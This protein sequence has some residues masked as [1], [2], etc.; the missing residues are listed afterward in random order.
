MGQAGRHTGGVRR[1]GTGPLRGPGGQAPAPPP[2]LDATTTPV[3]SS[4]GQGAGRLG[5]TSFTAQT[6]HSRRGGGV[7]V[8]DAEGHA[9]AEIRGPLTRPARPAVPGGAGALPAPW[10]PAPGLHSQG[11]RGSQ[12]LL[13]PRGLGRPQLLRPVG[14][15]AAVRRQSAAVGVVAEEP[16]QAGFESFR[17]GSAFRLRPPLPPEPLLSPVAK[18]NSPA[19]NCGS[20]QR[21]RDTAQA[22][23]SKSTSSPGPVL[24][25]PDSG[26]AAA[27]QGGDRAWR[28]R[29]RPQSRPTPATRPTGEHWRQSP[30]GRCE[31]GAEGTGKERGGRTP[32]R[33]RLQGPRSGVRSRQEA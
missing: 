26:A 4:P 28:R 8:C 18:A 17:E 25:E 22:L 10:P 21:E 24:T 23:P 33:G 14:K 5:A 7:S 6:Q 16:A 31:E 3:R 13:R 27:Q 32:G 11:G 9:P 2:Q 12:N 29:A 15:R 20:G 19:P 1:A 30:A